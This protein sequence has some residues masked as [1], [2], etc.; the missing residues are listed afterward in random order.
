MQNAGTSIS[1][2]IIDT[3]KTESF[4]IRSLIIVAG[5]TILCLIPFITK[6]F[7][8]DDTLFLWSAKHIQSNPTDFFGFN[9]NWYGHQQPM[10]LVNQ[11]PPLVSYFIAG[12]AFLFG[13]SETSLH[14]AFII[15]GVC[16]SIGMYFLA[17]FFCPRPYLAALIA[18]F[19]PVFLVSSTSVMT[20]ILMLT[21]YVWSAVLWLYG[22]EK[23]KFLYFLYAGILISFSALT[24]Y[25]GMTMIPLLFLYSLITK[26][27]LGVWI[28]ALLIPIFALIGYQLVTFLL[29]NNY[30]IF[31][32][33]AYSTKLRAANQ[34][35]LLITKTFTGLCYTG[36]SMV[37]ILFFTHL[38]WS[39]RDLIIGTIFLFLFIAALFGIESLRAVLFPSLQSIRYEVV[40]QYALFIF[41][42][43]Q[44]LV[45]ATVDVLKYR[46]PESVFLF[47]WIFGTFLF[48]SH[49]NWTISART[50]LPMIP[51]VGILV[52]R[53]LHEKF[54]LQK[55]S[56]TFLYTWPLIPAA[57]IALSVTWADASF[58]NCQRSAARSIHDDFSAYPHTIWFQGHWGFQY[59]MESHGAKAIDF[60]TSDIKPGDIIIIPITNTNTRMLPENQFHFV[61]KHNF[62]PCSWIGTMSGK[63]AGFY[64]NIFGP[65]PFYVGNIEP[66]VYLMFLAGNFNNPAKAIEY[67]GKQ[68]KAGHF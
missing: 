43:I 62:I 37:G 30:L 11:N 22:M 31:N 21:L 35:S 4:S 15:P 10:Y 9:V 7:H 63:Y 25:F 56:K 50:I 1:E 18:V 65:L 64:S 3:M 66:E 41:A 48:A 68:L 52:I 61:G 45:L 13:W 32:A 12:V 49:I 55:S 27:K 57:L 36:G 17:K 34:I 26:R 47:L 29:Y 2:T 67:F 16:L 33:A 51:A 59:Y 24:K 23:D 19:T 38:M 54:D 60:N 53:R 28:F 42:G 39:R 44:I 6:A 20:D 58:A 8:I 40:L 14:I 5:I 46:T